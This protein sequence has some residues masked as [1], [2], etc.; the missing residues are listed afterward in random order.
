MYVY[1]HT[2]IHIHKYTYRE[3]ERDVN[4]H[5]HM[6]TFIYIGAPGSGCPRR[7]GAELVVVVPR[8]PYIM[9]YGYVGIQ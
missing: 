4:V 1:M 5:I 7:V 8:R 6:I 3:R 9:L 2:Y